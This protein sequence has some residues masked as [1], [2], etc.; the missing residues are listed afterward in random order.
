LNLIVNATHSIDE[1]D[2]ENNRIKVRTWAEGGNVFAEVAD[3]GRGIPAEN[4]ERIFDPF[5]TTQDQGRGTGLGLA[6]SQRIVTELG[7]EICVESTLGVGSRFV[8]RLPIGQAKPKPDQIV[9]AE[10]SAVRGRI[11]IVDDEEMVRDVLKG[12]LAAHETVLARSG[13]EGRAVIEEDEE[14]DLILCDLIM[15]RMTGMDLHTWLA[16]KNPSLAQRTVF[17]TGG[18]FTPRASEYLA[19]AG[20]LMIQ[21]PFDDKSLQ[22]IVSELILAKMAKKAPGTR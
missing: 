2:V 13:E 16:E 17:I 8:V 15:P 10:P 19:R 1:G 22:R 20:N 21:K 4:L 14:F 5:F 18:A 11:L 3:T 7:G 6:I 9:A 12:M